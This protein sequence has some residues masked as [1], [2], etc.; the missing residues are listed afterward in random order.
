M[1]RL[2]DLRQI[3]ASGKVWSDVRE[4]FLTSAVELVGAEGGLLWDCSSDPAK[5]VAQ[6][7][8]GKSMRLP[9]SPADHQNLMDKAMAHGKSVFVRP[10]TD[11]E[12]QRGFPCL[13]LCPV[14]PAKNGSSKAELLEFLFRPF[15]NEEREN[16]ARETAEEIRAILASAAVVDGEDIAKT[17]P[18]VVPEYQ[19]RESAESKPIQLSFQ[20][21]NEYID[22]LNQ[23]I[24][25]KTVAVAIANESRRLMDCDRV[26][27]IVRHRG[28]LRLQS[29]SGQPSV[30]RRSNSTKLLEQLSRKV[31][32][33]GQSFWYPND[34]D[35]IPPQI[36]E[37]LDDYLA[38]SATRSLVIEPVWEKTTPV[39]EDPDSLERKNNRIIGGLVFEHCN[40]QWAR[41]SVEDV[42][43]FA[44]LH[45]GNA[46]RNANKHQDLFLYP[47]WNLLG[48]SKV[49]TAPRMLPKTLLALMAVLLVSLVLT[50]W[51]TDFYVVSE[52]VIV[53]VE[54]RNVFT[55][56]DGIVDQILVGHG[57]IVGNDQLLITL[58]NE[59]LRLRK[60]ET[61][62]QLSSLEERVS[63]IRDERFGGGQDDEAS[64]LARENLQ[65]L[66]AQIESLK[67]QLTILET[68]E[69]KTKIRSPL[70]GQVITWD[71]KE[72]LSNRPVR[73]GE[74]LLEVANTSGSWELELDLE[75]KR[76]GHMTRALAESKNGRLPISFLMAADPSTRHYGE[77]TEISL[78]TEVTGENQQTIKVK[79]EIDTDSLPVK[80]AGTGV[81]AQIVCGRSS[82]GYLWL[83]DVQEFLQKYVM[84]RF[85]TN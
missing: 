20:K 4:P 85:T 72:R 7:T 22:A 29:I 36:S 2:D 10:S 77:L 55:Q 62:G 47:V 13:L 27:V 81:T 65:S 30:N 61:T 37:V 3:L 17:N 28:K 54:K 82:L 51:R 60:Q 15:G 9:I 84:F 63:S 52:G 78:V 33:T 50:L 41:A 6:R 43:S 16:A 69:S 75:D 1:S 45:S 21:L 42:I 8:N 34:Q 39:V 23:S 59:E 12:D 14:D 80:Q 44:T 24:D 26:G 76:I 31:L 71:L 38:I 40:E 68:I 74:V 57:D 19:P 73:N 67:N 11:K 32:R 48:K 46:L 25:R 49:L 58:E 18:E 5:L 83:H 56:V 53:P 66:Q 79:V 35:A 70:A 64:S